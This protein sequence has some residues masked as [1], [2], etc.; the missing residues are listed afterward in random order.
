MSYFILGNSIGIAIRPGFEKKWGNMDLIDTAR[1]STESE[2][3]KMSYKLTV[4][5][6]KE[7]DY[8][9]CMNSGEIWYNEN[10]FIDKELGV[11]V[12]KIN[13]SEFM[14]GANRACPEWFFVMCE[15]MLLKSGC[16]WI[17]GAALEKNDGAILMPARG[18]VGKTATVVNM[19]RKHG[20]RLL[21]DDLE[22]LDSN[23]NSVHPF[24]KH[25]YIYG[26]HKNLFPE[27]FENNREKKPISNQYISKMVSKMIPTVKG[28]LKKYPTLLETARKLNPQ[29]I[30]V[31]PKKIFDKEQLSDGAKYIEK[32]IW[33]ERVKKR[34]INYFECTPENVA[35]RAAA[36]TLTEL[37]YGKMNMNL[38]LWAMCCSEILN[39]NEIYP[40]IYEIILNCIKDA[41][42]GILEIPEEVSVDELSEI[43]Y[44][45]VD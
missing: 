22:I 44:Q 2:F 39:Y 16:T 21:G 45:H 35:S 43:V 28:V 3:H 5:Y 1:L 10:K 4:G 17:H 24:L 34:D 15:M 42:T 32:V 11:C 41:K 26:Y 19:V 29:S 37:T 7:F 12:T 6:L 27:L 40:K 18:G 8:N 30:K 14:I 25:F 36:I 33:L 9:E 20:W 38:H 13:D 31:S 23:N